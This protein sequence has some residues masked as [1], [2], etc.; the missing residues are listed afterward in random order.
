MTNFDSLSQNIFGLVA[1]IIS[2]IALISTT[3]Q[4]LQQY[5]STADGYRRCTESVM[6][7]WAIGTHRKLRSSEFRFEVVFETPVLFLAPPTNRRG[8]INGRKIYYIDG[9]AESYKETR[10]LPPKEQERADVAAANRVQTADDERASWVTLLSTL[11][12]EEAESRKWDL[13][14]RNKAPPHADTRCLP[15][16]PTYML[17]VGLQSK[18]RS[19][20]FMPAAVT[21]PYA[22]STICHLVE[23]MTMLGLYWKLFDQ[24]TWNMRAEGNGFILTSTTVHGLGVMVAFGTTGKSK[25]AENRVIPDERLKDLPFGSVPNI[26]DNPSYLEREKDAQNLRLV[27]GTDREVEETLESLGCHPITLGKFSKDHK[28]MFSRK[29]LIIAVTYKF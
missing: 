7:L 23:M 11:Q 3:L 19:W 12:R 18:T 9:S 15:K 22:T 28:H 17:A 10:V 16:P 5:F 25:F 6:G 29:S 24:N 27:F 4:I 2:V 8:P 21:R 13:E 14:M 26:F 1:L 20:D